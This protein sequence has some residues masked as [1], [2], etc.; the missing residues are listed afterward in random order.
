[1]EGKECV[2]IY[3]PIVDFNMVGVLSFISIYD[4]AQTLRLTLSDY[5]NIF[6]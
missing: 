2:W 3:I 5:G 6:T 1:M 4:G